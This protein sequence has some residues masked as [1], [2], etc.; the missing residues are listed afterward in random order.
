MSERNFCVTQIVGNTTETVKAYNKG[1][2]EYGEPNPTYER[3]G[4]EGKCIKC[5]KKAKKGKRHCPRHLKNERTDRAASRD[6]EY[7]ASGNINTVDEGIISDRAV[8]AYKHP[9]I[10][11]KKALGVERL[12]AKKKMPA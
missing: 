9:T 11:K 7:E 12:G 6:K 3:R 1:M 4:N 10:T 5:E 2:R 8:V